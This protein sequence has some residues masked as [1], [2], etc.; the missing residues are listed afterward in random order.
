MQ[1]V[2]P[3]KTKYKTQKSAGE[4][5]TKRNMTDCFYDKATSSEEG[6]TDNDS[7]YNPSCDEEE[8]VKLS[9]YRARER[10]AWK[11]IVASS[12]ASPRNLLILWTR[13][14]AHQIVQLMDAMVSEYP[15]YFIFV[16]FH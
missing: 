13:S 1:Y 16:A 3:G 5:L 7:E 12:C 9:S 4:A 11:W 8:G 6:P 14:M 15:F 2:S 10:P